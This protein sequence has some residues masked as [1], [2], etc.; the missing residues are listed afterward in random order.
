MAITDSRY[1]LD[2][3]ARLGNEI[4]NR[5]VQPT[6]RAE[7]DGKFVAI[8]VVTGEFEIDEDDYTA[9]A[10]LRLRKP[11]ADMWLARAGFPTAYQ[12]RIVR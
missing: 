6:L 3:L 12:M 5:S 11:N 4:M 2:E 1:S 7:D 8:D 10:R 9:V